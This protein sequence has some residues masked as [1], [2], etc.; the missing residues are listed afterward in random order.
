MI[1]F[2]QPATA[3]TAGG[4]LVPTTSAIVARV[5]NR[6]PIVTAADLEMAV[7]DRQEIGA[8][9]ATVEAFFKPLKQLAH[10][11]HASLCAREK[12]LLAPLRDLDD[13]TRGAMSAFKVAQD[14]ERRQREHAIA[15]EQRRDREARAVAEAATL[16]RAGEHSMAAAVVAEAIAAPA[17]VVV[18][19]DVT[20]TIADLSFRRVWKW[21]YAGNDRARAMALLPRDYLSPDDVKIGAYA[22]TMKESANLP[23]IEFYA[24]DVPVR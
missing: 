17:P 8:A 18:L 15:E 14:R 13:R 4:E 12:S 24:E 16:E 7:A 11:L 1:D 19:P 21:R 23:G 10:Q 5:G 9:I 20:K 3:D 22:R 2:N 6:P